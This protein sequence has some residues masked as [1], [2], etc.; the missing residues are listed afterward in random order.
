MIAPA[1]LGR[2]GRADPAGTPRDDRGRGAPVEPGRLP[3]RSTRR[4]STTWPP[5]D[6]ADLAGFARGPGEADRRLDPVIDPARFAARY[7]F[8]L[9]AFQMRAIEALDDGESVLVA[10]PTGSGKTVVA[11]F[12]I[13]RALDA[14]RQVLLHDAAQGALEPE[15]R[16]PGRSARRGERRAAHRR[17]RDQRR[18]SGRGDDDGGAAQHAL[19]AQRGARRARDGRDGRGALPPG[20]VPGRR[21]G[22]G[23]D[24]PAAVD[25]GGVPVGHDLQRGGVRRVDRDAPR[26][27]PRRDRG[28]APGAARAPL[29]GRSRAP[30]DAR[31]A[32]RTG[33]CRTPTSSRSTSEE[34]R[35]KTYYRRGSGTRAA[36]ADPPAARGASPRL[37]AAAGGGRRGPRR[38]R[39]CSRRSTSCSAGPAATAASSG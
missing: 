15:V 17:Q 38:R 4:W 27:D 13:D 6:S 30:S 25:L 24:P 29:P 2:D 10:A 18:R 7:P 5:A 22:G 35:Y 11:E 9:D 28:E 34:V 8:A 32:E 14:D 39:D 1:D 3:R 31:R 37:R 21:V 36:P 16:R 19:R 33:R 23:A 12:A 20:P 26:R